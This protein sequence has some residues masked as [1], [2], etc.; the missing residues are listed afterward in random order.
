M[1]AAPIA[2]EHFTYAGFGDHQ[3]GRLHGDPGATAGRVNR[4]LGGD[5]CRVTME[6][7]ITSITDSDPE[8]LDLDEALR[9]PA[10]PD[11][12]QSKTVELRFF[13][14]M[15]VDDIAHVLGVSKTTVEADW[16]MARA[17]L[18]RELTSGKSS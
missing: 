6:E 17:W 1:A 16:R 11:G 18:R 7:G 12:R 15:T 14:G 10:A 2:L 5:L 9:R 4:I 8:L 3:G 13:G